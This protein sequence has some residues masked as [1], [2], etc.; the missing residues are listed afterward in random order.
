[1]EHL[2][3]YGEDDLAIIVEN[4]LG[5]TNSTLDNK[6][7]LRAAIIGLIT[8]AGLGEKLKCESV[9]PYNSGLRFTIEPKEVISQIMFLELLR[10]FQKS[11]K[12]WETESD[13]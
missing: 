12:R 3:K 5:I 2:F 8:V 1:M 11:L 9:N 7:G 6:E 13:Y 4:G 10:E